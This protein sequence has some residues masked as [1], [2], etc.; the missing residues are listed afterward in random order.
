MMTVQMDDPPR[1]EELQARFAQEPGRP[2]V[3][4]QGLGFVGAAMAA[5]VSSALNEAGEQCFNVIGVDRSTS[6]GLGR[7]AAVN[8][9][10]FPFPTTDRKLAPALKNSHRSGN[11]V[12]TDDEHVYGLASIILIDVNFDLDRSGER[13]RFAMEPFRAALAAIGKHM[14]PDALV[15]VETTV[16]PGTCERIVA[17]ELEHHLRARG[18]P[19]NE[20]LL[21]HAYERVMPGDHY[22]DSIVNFWRVYAGYTPDAADAC[23]RF[24]SALVNVTEFPLRRLQSTTASETAK[25]LENSYRAVTIAMMEEWGRFAELTG[26]DLFEIV[27]A[28]RVRPTHSNIRTPG[29]GVGGYCLTKDPLF[30]VVAARDLFG[31]PDVEFTFSERAV[32]VNSAMPLRACAR[33]KEKLGSLQGRML[34]LLGLAYRPDVGDT[35][36]S[37]SFDLWRAA[38]REGATVL[39]HDP[40]VEPGPETGSYDPAS[41]P[42]AAQIDA[43]VFAVDHQFYRDFD[44]KAW[45]KGSEPLIFDANGVL[46][47]EQRDM[48]MGLGC[49]V[50]SV[51]R[52]DEA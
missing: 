43:V 24:L 3:C 4:I 34:L 12:A 19:H 17:P 7:I 47:R 21:A 16:P 36:S 23:E 18:L 33:L 39:P 40:L 52:G 1:A 26:V 51:G 25:V 29:L 50:I 30:A 32:E 42:D 8:S 37:A 14:R 20:F 46:G 35:R 10:R 2:I 48:F 28:I 15:I 27:S 9:G 22:L 11:L 49:P 6:D 45:L 31:A 38:E 44:F 41:L 5:A 13:P